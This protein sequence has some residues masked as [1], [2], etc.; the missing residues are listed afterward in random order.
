MLF[1]IKVDYGVRLLIDLAQQP[2][3]VPIPAG[4]SAARQHVPEAFVVQILNTLQKAGLIESRRGPH[5]GHML[6]RPAS[7]ITMAEVVDTF[8]RRLAPMECVHEPDECTLS[9]ACSQRELWTDIERML[10][11]VLSRTSIA[12]LALRQQK[13]LAG[14]TA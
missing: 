11:D 7:E 1:P 14:A 12:D 3:G 5:G 4:S 8:E 6:A 2:Q 10:L 9:S 13:I